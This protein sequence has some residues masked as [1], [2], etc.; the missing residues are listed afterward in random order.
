MATR[1]IKLAALYNVDANTV[2]VQVYIT[3]DCDDFFH[4]EDVL[5]GY[6]QL[7]N[8]YNLPETGLQE[9][10]LERVP[11]S[12]EFANQDGFFNIFFVNPSV[13]TNIEARATLD[14]SGQGTVTASTIVINDAG[15]FTDSPNVSVVGNSPNRSWHL[16]K[17]KERDEPYPDVAPHNPIELGEN[18]TVTIDEA[19]VNSLNVDIQFEKLAEFKSANTL[20][21]N[22]IYLGGGG[23]LLPKAGVLVFQSID[24]PPWELGTSTFSEQGSP[25]VLPNNTYNNGSGLSCGAGNSPNGY[26]M[27]SPGISIIKSTL[28]KLQ[29]EGFNARAWELQV[30]GASPASIT[31]FTVASLGLETPLAFDTSKPIALSLLAGLEKN[32]EESD[33]TEAKLILNFF[34]FADRELP[35]KTLALDPADLFNARPLRPFS[36]SAQPSEYPPTTEKFTW[37]LEISSVDQGDFITIRTAVPSVTYTPFATSQVLEEQT[38]VTD[39]LSYAPATPFDLIEGAAVFNLAIGFDGTPIEEKYIFDTR[40]SAT[41]DKGV[42]LRVNADGTMTLLV[43]DD[44]TT[45]SVVS[46][47]I[48]AW[49]SGKVSEVVA[50]WS[51]ATPLMRISVDGTIVIEDTTTAL[52]ANLEDFNISSIQLGADASVMGNL[53]SEFIRAVFLKRPR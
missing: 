4:P 30:N 26:V 7:F 15:T 24:T 28:L 27:D 34:D 38:R 6:V 47:I 8:V 45:A 36:I 42:A 13:S 9:I 49:I 29:G 39:N 46:T 44:T 23:R 48:P 40:D 1:Q 53:D 18:Q 19:V 32:A 33:I 16:D 22:L 43:Q 17:D 3:D 31:P 50:E 12:K 41:L 14:I 10:P 20:D 37:R 11:V 5:S 52:P 35:S 25:Q 2:R 51:N 21:G